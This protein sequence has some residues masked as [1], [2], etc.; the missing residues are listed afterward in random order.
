MK[1]LTTLKNVPLAGVLALG[2][3]LLPASAMADKGDRGHDKGSSSYEKNKSFN[4]G[5][6]RNGTPVHRK[7]QPAGHHGDKHNKG[8]YNRHSHKQFI[9]RHYDKPHSRYINRV[10]HRH[11]HHDHNRHT[12]RHYAEY[13]HYHVYDD[14][15]FKIGV[16][17][18]N[19]DIVFQD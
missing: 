10:I 18:G 2:L 13:D 3:A 9:S 7:I 16:H 12:H 17:T 4:K 6:R 1:L 5:D 8:G 15:R 19:F 11:D 14:I